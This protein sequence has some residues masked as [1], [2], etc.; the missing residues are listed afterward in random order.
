VTELG[1]F[2]DSE[3]FVPHSGE[4]SAA[5]PEFQ[6]TNVCRASAL[7]LMLA[8]NTGYL[9]AP[10]WEP[11]SELGFGDRALDSL[12]S[13]DRLA[14]ALAADWFAGV[15]A[16]V[17]SAD[18]RAESW[19]E[20]NDDGDPYS[21][22]RFLLGV[23]GSPSERE[24]AAA[25]AA[26]F[27]VL[28]DQ[29]QLTGLLTIDDVAVSISLGDLERPWDGEAWQSFFAQQVP[30]GRTAFR[31]ER[32]APVWL[33]A[34]IRLRLARQ[35]PDP[36]T[37]SLALALRIGGPDQP[38]QLTTQDAVPTPAG[39]L[40][41]STMIHGTWGWK[42][43]WWRPLGGFHKFI[44]SEHRPNLYG[45]G[46][47]FSWSGAYSQKQ[48]NIAASDFVDWAQEV[49]PNGLQTVFSHSYGA[50]VAALAVAAGTSA[51]ELVLMSAPGTDYVNHA[52][53]IVNRVIDVRLPFDPV[54]ALARTPQRLAP[55]ES[56]TEVLLPWSL[57]HSASHEE[58][59]WQEV[60]VAGQAQL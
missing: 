57:D 58:Q 46:A 60:D 54:L 6:S 3:R 44:M 56:V 23:L 43:D 1:G 14:T 12:G 35:S 38:R 41:I 15:G 52:S 34:L 11:L 59:L 42:G 53:T 37:R 10:L 13:E 20:M 2:G 50:E 40:V 49:A 48:R 18:T 25:A 31:I 7:S 24:S 21:A 36:V 55:H 51:Q 16:D 26:L 27:N 47:R 29:P 30:D 5:G 8:F 22:M 28:R 4:T 33:L 39:A 19:R 9:T 45:R 17:A 32:T